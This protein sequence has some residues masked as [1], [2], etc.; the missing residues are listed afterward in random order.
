MKKTTEFKKLIMDEEI[1]VLPF[2][3][4]A[5]TAILAQKAGFKAIGRGGASGH[6]ILGMPDLELATLTEIADWTGKIV[7]AVDIPVLADVDT[8]F[9]NSTN[10]IRTVNLLEKAGAAGIFFED[11]VSPKR[12][13]ETGGVQVIPVEDMVA[14]IQAAVQTRKDPDFI[15]TARTDSLSCMGLDESIRRGNIY[16]EAG[17]D[18]I[19]IVSPESIEQLQRIGSEVKAPKMLCIMHGGVTPILPPKEYQDLGFNLVFYPGMCM[20][21]IVYEVNNMFE[22][23]AKNQD[24]N[25]LTDKI[26][27][28]KDVFNI[29]GLKEVRSNEAQ[30]AETAKKIVQAYES[31]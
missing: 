10:V 5:L 12:C 6:H 20:G 11:Q 19:F 21:K 3:V 26:I 30:L 27:S 1:L 7:D 31:K 2:V 24:L 17:A 16:H 9:G 4:D 14:K 28:F 25:R 13:G 15:I 22:D 23:F 8:G 29:V 18:V